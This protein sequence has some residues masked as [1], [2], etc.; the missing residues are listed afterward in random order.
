MT[1]RTKR[2]LG[3]AIIITTIVALIVLCV[4]VGGRTPSVLAVGIGVIL[5]YTLFTLGVFLTMTS[6]GMFIVE[7]SGTVEKPSKE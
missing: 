5:F 7:D 6:N 4:A 3:W 2:K 1:A